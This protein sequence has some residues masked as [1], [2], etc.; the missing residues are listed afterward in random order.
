MLL[1]AKYLSNGSEGLLELLGPGIVG[2]LILPG[3]S[4]LPDATIVLVS[5][6]SGSQDIAQIEVSV[7]MG[8]VA[9]STVM[10]LTV[11]WGSCIVAGKCDLE[12]STT[13]DSQDTKGFS[14]TG[15]GVSTDIW[16][17][18]AARIMLISVIPFL[19][20]QIPQPYCTFEQSRIA[21]LI[22]L[23]FSIFFLISYFLYQ[24]FRQKIQRRRLAYA[25]HKHVVL[26]ILKHYTS[27]LGRLRNED[28]TP[29]KDILKRLFTE[30]DQDGNG[31]LS[32]SELRAMITGI[33]VAEIEFNADD[34]VGNIMKEFDISHDSQIDFEE[35]VFGIS[36]WLTKHYK[37]KVKK[38]LSH[39][40]TMEF[41]LATDLHRQAKHE[42]DLLG[43]CDDEAVEEFENRRWNIIKSVSLLVVG[44]AIA[45]LFAHPFVDSINNFSK[46]TN[47]PSFFVAFVVLPFVR[48]NE[49]YEAVTFASSKRNR[50]A[51][52][53]LS[54]IYAAITMN[55]NLCLSVFLGVLY[56][57][58]LTWDFSAEVSIILMV[59]LIVGVSASFRTTFPLWTSLVAF[60][61]YPFSP[62]LVY[63]INKVILPSS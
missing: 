45:I 62:L 29:N 39:S 19:I 3:L 34:I 16:T 26:G 53:T 9:G 1:S 38:N 6:L 36:N 5:G 15:S 7:G 49:A 22:S 28:G 33:Q 63:F 21:I 44:L 52:L 17:R 46:V 10:A 42:H 24:V 58:G 54:Q 32:P 25:K 47:I 30:M 20:V 31:F 14:L 35:F 56:V 4:T 61:L 51:S 41:K 57:R 8:L 11:L 37:P 43:N 23:V 2:G 59:S 13:K 18:D 50:T 12:G 27:T 60:A 48:F 40:K 55:H